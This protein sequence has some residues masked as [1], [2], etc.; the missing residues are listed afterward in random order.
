MHTRGIRRL[1]QASC[2]L[3]VVL[4]PANVF[5]EKIKLPVALWISPADVEKGQHE[6]MEQYM[7]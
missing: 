5:A 7:K 3:S 4:L 1:F 2:I 6:L